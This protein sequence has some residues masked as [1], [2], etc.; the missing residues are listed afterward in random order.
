MYPT[1]KKTKLKFIIHCIV[2]KKIQ[3]AYTRLHLFVRRFIEE[4]NR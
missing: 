1:V 2:V 3:E 4:T